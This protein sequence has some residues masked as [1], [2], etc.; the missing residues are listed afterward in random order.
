MNFANPETWVQ[1]ALLI[2][3]GILFVMKVPGSIWQSLGDTG[4][5]VR[6]ELDE[7]VRIRQEAQSL[8]N[9]IKA[10]RLEAEAKARD[11][12]ATAEAEAKRLADEAAVKLEES[13]TRRRAL[14]EKRIAQAESQAMAEV[15]A[16]AAD[17]AARL[18][19]TV[20]LERVSGLKS[21]DMI[22]TA[23]KQIDKRLS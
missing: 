21:D 6:A 8:L 20:L 22:D 13:L 1:I 19:E 18:T 12:V 2:F 11:L 5:A 10:E 3:F 14:A 23:I 7:A 16:A 17:L 15:K 4:N 9:K